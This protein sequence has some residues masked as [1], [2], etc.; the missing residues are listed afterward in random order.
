MYV[1]VL[2]VEHYKSLSFPSHPQHHRKEKDMGQ[3]ASKLWNLCESRWLQA[4]THVS[5]DSSDTGLP[6]CVCLRESRCMVSP[7]ACTVQFP[8]TWQPIGQISEEGMSTRIQDPFLGCKNTSSVKHHVWWE[9]CE[10]QRTNSAP[11]RGDRI[12]NAR[13]NI[14][15]QSL[16]FRKL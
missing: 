7:Y 9:K 14:K 15:R 13:Q 2:E 1:H 6:T 11:D 16:G 4:N 12:P 10:V 3:L 8:W 5:R